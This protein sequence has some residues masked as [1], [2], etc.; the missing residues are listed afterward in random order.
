MLSFIGFGSYYSRFIPW[1]EVLVKTLRRLF[2][3]YSNASI[4]FMSYLPCMLDT[5]VNI[6]KVIVDGPC[7]HRPSSSLPF[8]LKTDYYCN[9]VGAILL[10]PDTSTSSLKAIA[11]LHR[12]GVCKFD[13]S[14]F[15]LLLY[16]DEKILHSRSCE[17]VTLRFDVNKFHKY[18]W[19]RHFFHIFD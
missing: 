7:P 14:K 6:K 3:R 5:F 13:I 19:G 4:P 12:T 16:P 17:C 10:Q 1:F 9:G 2:S 15:G 11:Y 18:L 8:F